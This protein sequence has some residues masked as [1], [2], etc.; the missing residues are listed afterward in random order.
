[1]NHELETIRKEDAVTLSWNLL[2]ETL[3]KSYEHPQDSRCPHRDSKRWL[4][5]HEY[6]ALTLHHPARSVNSCVSGLYLHIIVSW[7]DGLLRAIISP[8]PVLYTWR[9]RCKDSPFLSSLFSFILGSSRF[10]TTYSTLTFFLYLDDGRNRFVR[11]VSKCLPANRRY[12]PGWA[13]VSSST[14]SLLRFWTKLFFT[15]WGC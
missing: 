7:K 2:V 4:L 6:R 3:R 14:T 10:R 12:S 9:L 13:L 8:R 11:N 15:G 1:M 5:A